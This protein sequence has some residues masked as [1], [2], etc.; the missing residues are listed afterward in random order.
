MKD[1]SNVVL[2]GLGPVGCAIAREVLRRSDL[3]VVGAVDRDPAKVGRDLGELLELGERLGIGIRADSAELLRET[4]PDL[5]V[6]T[7]TWS[8]ERILPQI[9]EVVGAGA[10]VVT[11]C[12]E[13]SYPW[14]ARPELA[15][16]IHQAALAGGASVLSTGVN[17]GF[18]MDYLPATVS[19]LCRDVE[20]IEVERLMDA[21]PRRQPFRQKIGAGA[22]V[23]EFEERVAAGTLRHVGLRESVDMIA[24]AV[25]WEL[26]RVEETIEPVVAERTLETESQTVEEG[27]VT[28]VLQIARGLVEDGE[29]IVLT[30]RACLGQPSPHDRLLIVGT[31]RI[32]LR[33]EGGVHG[34]LATCNVVVNSIPAVLAA[35]PGLKTMLDLAV[36]RSPV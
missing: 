25:G 12:E 28:G 27:R 2:Y 23:E 4:S 29:R 34:D 8:L 19:G 13:L 35:T 17:P 20:R 32:D 24:R 33:I 3:E 18:L 10:S 15:R 5:V 14:S 21:A 16:R 7:T 22:T 26:S 9:L 1:T 11:T 30:F 36:A 6:L 31:P